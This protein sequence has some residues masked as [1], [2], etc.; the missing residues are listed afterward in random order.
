MDPE[1]IYIFFKFKLLISPLFCRPLDSAALG[2]R[3]AQLT[4]ATHATSRTNMLGCIWRLHSTYQYSPQSR[5][6]GVSNFFF[7]GGG[8]RAKEHS[9]H[10]GP[11]WG[12]RVNKITVSGTD[13]C[14]H[15]RV[16][17]YKIFTPPGLTQRRLTVS[18]RRF[19]ATCRSLVQG[20]SSL[21]TWRWHR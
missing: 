5:T 1:N 18:Y 3:T 12:P 13:N 7:G 10:F 19:E 14:L 16:I 17:L 11:V 15:W 6:S 4:L 2:S 8:L 20:S 21:G 9:S